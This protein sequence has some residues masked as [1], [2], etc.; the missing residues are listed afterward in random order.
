MNA[1]RQIVERYLEA[2]RGYIELDLPDQALE[3]LGKVAGIERYAFSYHQLRGDAYRQRREHD[4]ALTEF[5]LAHEECPSDLSVS[6][7]MAWC[8]KRLDRLDQ[9]VDVMLQAYKDHP[10][11]PIVLY[12]LACYYTL[13]GQKSDALSW[14]G[15]ALRM[16]SSLRTLIDDESDF[17]PL[18]SDPD[19]KFLTRRTPDHM[20]SAEQE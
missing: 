6:L 10:K 2:A 20:K 14:L 7:G 8:L 1:S 12:N 16:E 19:F 13:A 3:E 9:A 18:R 17:N 11:E 4:Q 5:M 15:R